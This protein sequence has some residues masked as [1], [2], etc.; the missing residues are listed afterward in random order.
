MIARLIPPAAGQFFAALP[1]ADRPLAWLW[2]VIL[3]LRGLL[4][5]LFAIAMGVPSAPSSGA[6]RWRKH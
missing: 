6:T 5:A 4:P 2:W 3:V 1:A